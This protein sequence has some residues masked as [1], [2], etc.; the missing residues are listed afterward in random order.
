[1]KGWMVVFVSVLLL[2]VGFVPTGRAE[3]PIMWQVELKFGQYK[4]GIDS[5][6][7]DTSLP[8]KCGAAD[9]PFECIYGSGGVLM[10]MVEVDLQF[11]RGVGSLA[12]GGT[13]GYALDNGTALDSTTGAKPGDETSFNVVPMQLSLVYHFD[14]LAIEHHVPF[15]PFAKAGFDYWIW[16]MRN[17]QDEIATADGSD[18]LGGTFGWHVGG[19]VKFLLDW[20]APDM[21]TTFDLEMGVNNSYLFAEFIYSSVDDFGSDKSL[22]LGDAFWMFG[23][24]FEL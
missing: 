22:R 7:S 2:T 5:E 8:Y 21:A 15:V 18:A 1:M 23:L 17:S 12:V 10:G 24:A 11:W 19:G 9:G 14:W 6:F 13:I 4:A 20:L 16:W 3:S